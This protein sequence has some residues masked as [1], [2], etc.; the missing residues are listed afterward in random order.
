MTML[1]SGQLLDF[2]LKK[3]STSATDTTYVA[4]D[5]V[6]ADASCFSNPRTA[7][8][9]VA[10]K[11]KSNSFQPVMIC[12]ASVPASPPEAGA[13]DKEVKLDIKLDLKPVV[14]KEFE[15]A[16]ITL[17]AAISV[18]ARCDDVVSSTLCSLPPTA[19]GWRN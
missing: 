8:D 17:K 6:F 13:Q 3:D 2:A 19:K 4:G 14:Q 18:F 16:S 1:L 10:D 12:E 15:K 9:H 11:D 5:V 7:R